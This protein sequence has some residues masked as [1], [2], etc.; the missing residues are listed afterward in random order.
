MVEESLLLNMSFMYVPSTG[1]PSTANVARYWPNLVPRPE[2]RPFLILLFGPG[3]EASI[4]SRLVCSVGNC[5]I[6]LV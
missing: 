1:H 4:G 6:G 5:Y 2:E 3:N